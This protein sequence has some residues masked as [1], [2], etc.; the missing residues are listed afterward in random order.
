MTASDRNREDA[1][2]L[3]LTIEDN[4]LEYFYVEEFN[5]DLDDA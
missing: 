2:D 4:L 3:K 5:E 1:D